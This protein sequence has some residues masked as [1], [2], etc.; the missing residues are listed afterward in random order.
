MRFKAVNNLFSQV[1]VKPGKP[2]AAISYPG[3][4]GIG[5]Q[6]AYLP[7]VAETMVR[8]LDKSEALENFAVFQMR[9]HWDAD[10][11][12]MIEAIRKAAGNPKIRVGQTPWGLMRLLAL[13]VPLFRELMEMR[14]LWNAPIRMDNERLK[15][16]LGA[17]PHTPLDA[18]VRHTL[19]G[20]GCVAVDGPVS[21]ARGKSGS[22]AVPGR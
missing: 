7:D 19:I 18:A 3:P 9:G 17:E 15:A 20:L 4:R 5:H 11:T 2:V 10:G 21:T 8:L 22:A 6:W 1:L 12:H 16:V 13:F 14:Y